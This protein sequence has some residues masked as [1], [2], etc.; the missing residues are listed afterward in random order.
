M[1]GHRALLAAV[2]Q[3]ALAAKQVQV[4]GQPELVERAAEVVREARQKL[5]QL[6]AES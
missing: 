5:Y 1:S 3:L 2:D 6:L 4:A